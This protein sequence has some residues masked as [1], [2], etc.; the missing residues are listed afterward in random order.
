METLDK[1]T[2]TTDTSIPNR[3]QD[4]EERVSDVED[5]LAETD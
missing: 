4:M 3:I 5:T 1:Q 2:E